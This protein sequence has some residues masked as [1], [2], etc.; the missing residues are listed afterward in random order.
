MASMMQPRKSWLSEIMPLTIRPALKR[1]FF[2]RPKRKKVAPDSAQ[3]GRR[4]ALVLGSGMFAPAWYLERNPDVVGLDP[5][6]HYLRHGGTEGRAASPSFDSSWYLKQYP[7]VAASGLNPLVHY[8]EHGRREGRIPAIRQG[9]LDTITGLIEELQEVEPEIRTEKAF[10]ELELLR[11]SQSIV[12]CRLYETW[13]AIYASLQRPYDRL[14]FVAGFVRG[15]A[16]LVA[17]NAARAVVETHGPHS[18]L[19]VATDQAD[20]AARSWFPSEADV[21]ILSDFGIDLPHLDRVRIVEMLISSLLPTAALTVNSLACWD[22]IKRRG[23]ALSNMTDLYGT[24]FCR[25]YDIDG[26]PIGY[27]DTHF[28]HCLPFMKR[29]YF[30]NTTFAN[31]LVL[32]FDLPPTLTTQ[33]TSVHQ[34]ISQ[35]ILKRPYRTPK[36]G[37]PFPVLWSGRFSRQKNIDV[38]ISVIQRAPDM[39]FNVYGSDDGAYTSKLQSLSSKVSNLTI[40]GEFSSAAVLPTESHGAYLFTSRWEGLPMTLVDMAARGIPI[41]APDLGGIT[42]LVNEKTGWLVRD[43]NDPDAYIHA[44]RAIRDDVLESARRVE[45]MGRHVETQHS[46]SAYITALSASPSFLSKA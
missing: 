24:M 16:E 40:K 44:L 36:S 39:Q 37:E 38:L 7:D 17:A 29:I 3:H 32:R 25:D 35:A 13:Q 22:A 15:G 11:A 34:P 27:A 18:V 43:Y 31:E 1:L 30:D 9:V 5:L 6:D 4:R 26:R 46:W 21:L 12:R 20:V 23:A 10:R 19:L 14:I 8:L 42:E 28:R 33:L 45:A 41:V 2:D